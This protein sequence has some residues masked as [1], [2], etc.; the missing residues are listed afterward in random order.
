MLENTIKENKITKRLTQKFH[1]Q[2]KAVYQKLKKTKNPM[3][4]EERGNYYISLTPH[5]AHHA[6]DFHVNL[7]ALPGR[8]GRGVC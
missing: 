4:M 7:S 2:G 1:K 5:H 6:E 3:K 8:G